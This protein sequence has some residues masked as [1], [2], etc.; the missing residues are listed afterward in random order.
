MTHLHIGAV[1]GDLPVEPAWAQQRLIQH[2]RPVGRR[3][4]NDARVALQR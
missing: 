1:D 2:I 3:N 4:H